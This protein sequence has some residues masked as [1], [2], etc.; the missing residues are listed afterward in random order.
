[1]PTTPDSFAAHACMRVAIQ[2]GGQN[3]TLLDVALFRS[4][5]QEDGSMR[6]VP[7]VSLEADSS[8][9]AT[10]AKTAKMQRD[11]A[12]LAGT[13]NSSGTQPSGGRGRE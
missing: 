3:K 9:A 12:K 5:S 6:F 10:T 13:Y 7:N 2:T 11:E 8:T 4:V 1:M